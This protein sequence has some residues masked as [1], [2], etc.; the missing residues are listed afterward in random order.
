[1][2]IKFLIFQSRLEISI[3]T[4]TLK[5]SHG[6]SVNHTD[7]IKFSE[8]RFFS[9]HN[10]FNPKFNDT[11]LWCEVSQTTKHGDV[12]TTEMKWNEKTNTGILCVIV[13]WCCLL[14][15]QRQTRPALRELEKFHPVVVMRREQKKQRKFFQRNQMKNKL[16]GDFY[17]KLNNFSLLNVSHSLNSLPRCVC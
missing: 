15:F 5:E 10:S 12:K 8:I 13:V 3:S 7:L 4:R 1:M 14:I 6:K 17:T 11:S 2:L 9:E 16:F